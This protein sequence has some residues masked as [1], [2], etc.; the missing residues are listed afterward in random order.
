M[1]HTTSQ[2]SK[3][4]AK[5]KRAAP[6]SNGEA[7]PPVFEIGA[8]GAETA[9]ARRRMIAEEAYLRAERRGF[10]QGDPLDD[11]LQA[12]REVDERLRRT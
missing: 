1:Q 8:P 4:S 9:E 2:K 12:E 5:R 10:G 11:W 3:P 7:R 6:A